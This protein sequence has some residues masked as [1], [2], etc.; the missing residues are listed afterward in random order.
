VKAAVYRTYGPP[1]VVSIEDRPCPRIGDNDVLIRV[2][3][4]T[5]SSGDWRL[6]TLT[7]PAGLGLAMRLFAGLRK[8]RQPVLGTELS[9]LV[10]DRGKGVTDWDPGDRVVAFPGAKMGAHAE[11]VAMPADGCLAHK[12]GGLSFGEAAAIPFG[13]LTALEFLRDKGRLQAGERILIVGASGAVGSA[14]VQLAAHFGAH[15]TGVCSGENAG[16]VRSL[17]AERV[18][19]YR[20]ED[21]A[22]GRERFDM[23]LDTTA[24][25]PWTRVRHMLTPKGRLVIVSSS[26]R[27]MLRAA[28]NR[29]VIGGVSSGSHK[30]LR[31]LVRLVE[32]GAFFPLVDRIY[33]FE[34]IVRA[35]AHVD[36]GRK[37]GAV[38]L[39]IIPDI[40]RRGPAAGSADTH[41]AQSLR[42]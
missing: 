16:L 8:P 19:D 14:A 23:I 31:H 20:R 33:P 13:G 34:H 30:G 24:S 35:H 12:P 32:D 40:S 36:S 9:G 27:D 26:A 18:I 38:V 1:E 11:Y 25:A 6:R 37:K 42:A 17:G 5:V 4:T 15:V 29:R 2:H 10:V 21:F 28:V 39:S 7:V 22:R 41:R 3:A